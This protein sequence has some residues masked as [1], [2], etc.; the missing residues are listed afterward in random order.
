MGKAG[1]NVGDTPE[2]RA[3]AMSTTSSPSAE[4]RQPVSVR[5][6]RRVHHDNE[7]DVPLPERDETIETVEYSDGFGR[8]LQTRTQ[9]EDVVFGDPLF[10]DAGLPADQPRRWATP[11]ASSAT[12][13]APAARRGERLADLRQQ[14]ARGREVRAVLLHAA[15]TTRRRPR[16]SSARR[17]RCSTTRAARSIR[18]VNP[19]GSEQRVVYGVPGMIAAPIRTRRFEPTPWETYTY[20]AND[21]A[22]RTHPGASAGY[23]HHWNTPASIVVDALGRTVAAVARN[24]PDPDTDWFID[25][26]D[27]RHPRQPAHRHRCA[28]PLAFQPRLRSRQP[29]AARR[30]HR[31]RHAAH[32][33]RRRRQSRRSARQQGRAR[34]ARLRRAE[35][36]DPALGARRQPASRSPCASGSSTATAPTPG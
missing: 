5:T 16:R 30:Q 10:G 20:D 31:R 1:E 15:G 18:T 9:A 8:L 22:G 14:G 26:L 11:S 2:A 13:S 17:R 28:R 19:D 21:N 7:T 32:R 29:P 35:P 33:P 4:R 27:L 36:P 34:P 3:Y 24:G 6:I 12:A 23:Q 25:P